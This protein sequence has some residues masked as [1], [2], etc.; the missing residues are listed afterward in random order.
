MNQKGIVS[1]AIILTVVGIS[2]IVAGILAWQNQKEKSLVCPQDTKLCPDGSYVSRTG[3][4]CEFASC[5]EIKEVTNKGAEDETVNW[6]TYRNEQYGFQLKYPPS[7][8][9]ISDKELAIDPS[10]QKVHACVNIHEITF[11]DPSL[12]PLFWDANDPPRIPALTIYVS[13]A[14]CNSIFS[15]YYTA[16]L[17]KKISDVATELINLGVPHS[18][19]LEALFKSFW[20][21]NAG[22]YEENCE[23]RS[24][25]TVNNHYAVKGYKCMTGPVHPITYAAFV[26]NNNLIISLID[27]ASVYDKFDQI[28]STFQFI[29]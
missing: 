14:D 21:N 5:P 10:F 26:P 15:S 24:V 13:Q 8:K 16:P 9:I 12:R 22:Y 18:K 23:K 20:W 2:I 7:F 28:L 17:P 29:K 27:H 11:I 3:P 4:N 25:I 6:K 19:I 1:T